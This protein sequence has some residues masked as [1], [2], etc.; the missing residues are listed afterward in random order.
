[1]EQA[2]AVM[3]PAFA[4][5]PLSLKGRGQNLGTKRAESSNLYAAIVRAGQIVP[6]TCLS[7]ERGSLSVVFW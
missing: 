1:M 6:K 4:I 2:A 5:G 3:Q 7:Y